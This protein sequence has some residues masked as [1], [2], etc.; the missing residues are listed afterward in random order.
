MEIKN[1]SLYLNREQTQ[2]FVLPNNQY[3]KLLNFPFTFDISWPNSQI[4]GIHESG[5]LDMSN[6]TLIVPSIHTTSMFPNIIDK[7]WHCF[8]TYLMFLL[9]IIACILEAINFRCYVRFDTYVCISRLVWRCK[10]VCYA[11]KVRMPYC[12]LNHL[13]R[14]YSVSVH[15]RINNVNKSPHDTRARALLII[16]NHLM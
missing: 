2:Y 15:G 12:G 10:Y 11:N 13:Y 1:R 7:K 3:F 14:I 16:I 8:H 9:I 5:V 6:K 4:H